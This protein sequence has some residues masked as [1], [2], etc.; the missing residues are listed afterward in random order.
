MLE[1]FPLVGEAHARFYHLPRRAWRRAVRPNDGY[2]ALAQTAIRAEVLPVLQQVVENRIR[3]RSPYVDKVL[4][5]TWTGPRRL[6]TDL[7]DELCLHCGLKGLAPNHPNR[8][9][10][11]PANR[12]MPF[13]P[14]PYEAVLR[15]WIGDEAADLYGQHWPNPHQ[16]APECNH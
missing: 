6:F 16:P 11:G 7:N 12:R 9:T 14:D 13:N 5:R 3:A 1:R 8:N 4:W 10:H 2:A 15:R